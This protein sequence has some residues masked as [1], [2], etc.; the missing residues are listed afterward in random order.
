MKSK[1]KFVILVLL[2]IFNIFCLFGISRLREEKLENAAWLHSG[3]IDQYKNYSHAFRAAST[4]L[5][6]SDSE[7]TAY[8]RGASD[9]ALSDP[10]YNLYPEICGNDPELAEIFQTGLPDALAG[11]SKCGLNELT[12]ADRGAL[13]DACGVIGDML[14]GSNANSLAGC[15]QDGD[16]SSDS[17]IEAK[18]TITEN[19]QLIPRLINEVQ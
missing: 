14:N 5:G 15:V 9:F 6:V 1:T 8:M 10:L 4:M 19:L 12:D 11:L 2:L 7:F 18:R 3:L 13:S 16:Y 17:Y